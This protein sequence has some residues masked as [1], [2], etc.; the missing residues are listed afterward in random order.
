MFRILF[1]LTLPYFLGV[2]SANAQKYTVDLLFSTDSASVYNI[3]RSE[4]SSQEVPGVIAF[5]IPNGEEITLTRTLDGNPS[6]GALTRDGA[7]YCINGSNLVFSEDN[8]EGTPNLFPDLRKEGKHTFIEHFFTTMTPYCII[9]ILFIAAIAFAFLGRMDAFRT[10]SLIGMPLCILLAS[11]LEIWGF[12]VLGKNVFWW[13]DYDTYGFFGSLFR[14]IPY[15]LFVAFQ[16]YS[17]KLYEKILFA[18]DPNKEISIKPMAISMGACIPATLAAAILCA[19]FWR[20]ATDYISLVV[21]LLTLGIGT[22]ISCRRNVQAA[23]AFNGTMLTAFAAVYIIGGLIA[24][25][26]LIV[27]IFRLILQILMIIAGIILIA[28]VGTTRYKDSRGNVYEEDGFG[29]IRRIN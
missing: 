12:A 25:W 5:K 14:A 2:L 16:V 22:V 17:I 26:G 10:V 1:I 6:I 8:P 28:V 21:F 29:N 23:G 11:I 13:C 3:V 24:V 19:I 18:D 7:E 20:S 4:K 27:V 15:V 9:A